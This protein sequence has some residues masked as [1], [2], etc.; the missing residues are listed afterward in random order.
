MQLRHGFSNTLLAGALG[1]ACVLFLSPA[2]VQAEP[3]ADELLGKVFEEIEAKRLDAALNHVEALL[4]AKPNFRLAYLIKA[5]ALDFLERFAQQVVGA[6]VCTGG[7][8]GKEE[9][10][11]E[12]Q[13]PGDQCF[14]ESA[15]QPHR[16]VDPFFTY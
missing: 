10:T 3:S 14:R 15:P 1:L 9:G 2:P 11:G 7:R 6:P 5:L 8:G 12:A 16:L 4:R 13:G